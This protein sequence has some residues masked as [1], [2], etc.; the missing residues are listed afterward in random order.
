MK[1]HSYTVEGGGQFPFDMLR[2]DNAWPLSQNDV[3]I[4]CHAGRRKVT[5]N[6]IRPPTVERWKSFLWEVESNQ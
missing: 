1:I 5:L 6:G 4:M 3:G 2:Y